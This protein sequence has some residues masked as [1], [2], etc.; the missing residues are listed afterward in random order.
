[1]SPDDGAILWSRPVE[2]FRGMNI[3]TPTVV[4]TGSPAGENGDAARILTSTYGGG[5]MLFEVTKDEDDWAV[6]TVWENT[7]QGY[8]SSPVVVDGHAYQHL[9]NDRVVCYDLETGE[10]TWTSKPFGGYWSTATDGERILAL[11]ARGDLILFAADP[12][13][14]TVLGERHVTDATSWAHLA[15]T[16]RPGGGRLFVRALDELIAYEY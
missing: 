13:E 1:M 7:R 14:F 2:A 15:V 3:L 16:P 4:P 12:A 6:E 11:D 5:T 8:M 10:S 9:K